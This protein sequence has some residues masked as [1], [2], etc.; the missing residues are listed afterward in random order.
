MAGEAERSLSEMLARMGA[1]AGSGSPRLL[2]LGNPGPGA[3][4]A[5]AAATTPKGATGQVNSIPLGALTGA[6]PPT[7]LR[8][9]DVMPA[10]SIGINGQTPTLVALGDLA[11]RVVTFTAPLCG[12]SIYIGGSGV[13]TVDFRLP[14]GLPYDIVTPGGQE[15]Y[16]VTDAPIFLP[17][18][19][20]IA[21]LLIGDR[22]RRP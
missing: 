10:S 22:Q 12:F 3:D 14:G 6:P 1:A 21:A 18:Q 19:V 5:A 7:Q 15:W 17:L 13:R 9:Y 4:G 16:A 8:H 2:S 11:S 20:Q